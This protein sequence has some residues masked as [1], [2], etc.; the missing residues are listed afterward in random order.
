VGSEIEAL[1]IEHSLRRVVSVSLGSASRDWLA[2]LRPLGASLT[3][4][5][6][7]VGGDYDEY[8][9]ALTALDG[10]EEVA[11]IGLGGINR[12]LFSGS[13]KYALRKA[14]EMASVVRR[15][16]VCDGSALKQHWEPF[17]V[18]A[19]VGMGALRLSGRRA[20]MVCAVDRW[21]LA[22]ALREQGAEVLCGD[23]MFALGVPVPVRSW[24]AIT[25]L[26]RALLPMLTR[27]VPFEWLYPT[28]ESRDVP[29]YRRW[30]DWADVIAGDWK[31]I[32][33]HMPAER[34]SLAGKTVLTNTT[35]AQDVEALRE[36]G[37]E[38]LITTTP[39]LDGRSFGTNAVEAAA[40]ALSGRPPAGMGLDDYL[41]VFR[42]LGWD[43]P[44]VERL[45]EPS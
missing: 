31:F 37:V 43:R 17:V 41:A 23:L 14:E 6:R 12:Y 3:I 30:Y 9:K 2:D 11:A 42:P 10:D 8:V 22:E 34:G 13:R 20:L 18:R 33:K 35:T 5:R 28:G 24:S 27:R 32:A 29:K 19:A 38:T 21:A 44:R 7:G 45:Q 25:G 4:E 15:K 40:A 16:P 1:D 36:R 39:V 26:G